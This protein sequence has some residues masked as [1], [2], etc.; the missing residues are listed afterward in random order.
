MI[1]TKQFTIAEEH[2]VKMLRQLLEG[3]A[4]DPD[5]YSHDIDVTSQLWMEEPLTGGRG[6]EGGEG[7]INTLSLKTKACT[8]AVYR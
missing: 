7:S 5:Q 1:L 3:V 4:S 8:P 6:L 2:A